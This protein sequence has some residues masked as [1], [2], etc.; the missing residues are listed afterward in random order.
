MGTAA[1][2]DRCT[3][4]G[5]KLIDPII[6]L[7]PGELS[8]WKPIGNEYEYFGN[9]SVGDIWEDPSGT[10]G[11]DI[12]AGIAPLDIR[13]LNHPTWGLGLSTSANG[14]VITTIGPP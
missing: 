5:P 12:A 9:F 3:T 4:V 6:T 13:D 10:P 14:K 7:S 11:Y 2:Y 8:T 1:I